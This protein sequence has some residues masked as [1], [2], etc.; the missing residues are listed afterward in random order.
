MMSMVKTTLV[1]LASAVIGWITG[2]FVGFLVYVNVGP[3]PEPEGAYCVYGFGVGGVIIALVIPAVR[4]AIR[5]LAKTTEKR[6]IP[7]KAEAEGGSKN[8]TRFPI[9]LS[10]IAF[11][12]GP[13][14][15]LIGG[16]VCISTPLVHPLDRLNTVGVLMTLGLIAGSVIAVGLLITSAFSARTPSE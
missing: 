3:F 6:P 11:F 10:L 12:V 1:W 4:N 2:C 13:L 16:L 14:L 7:E 8:I 5:E 15:G 9:P